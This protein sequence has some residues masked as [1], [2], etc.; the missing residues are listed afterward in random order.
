MAAKNPEKYNSYMNEYMKKRYRQRMDR[1]IDIL[2]GKCVEC[3]TTDNLQ[4]DHVDPTTK[5]YDF[6]KIWNRSLD[7]FDAELEKAQ[8]LC[9]EHH[10]AK[11]LVQ[12]SVEHGGGKSG[13]R[14]CKC[15]PC[16]AKKAEYMRAYKLR[17]LSSIV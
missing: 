6:N 9:K 15:L 10:Q 8:L 17:P 11:T 1:A 14:N 13:K 4:L 7:V 16:K 2:G 5:T 12:L 3:G